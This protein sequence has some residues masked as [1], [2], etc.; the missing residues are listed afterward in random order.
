MSLSCRLPGLRRSSSRRDRFRDAVLT[1]LYG[2]VPVNVAADV[3]SRVSV[4]RSGLTYNRS[5]QQYAGTITFTNSSTT[6]IA[7][8]LRLLLFGLTL[9]VT[10]TDTTLTIGTA[11]YSLAIGTTAAGD[12]FL[13][14]PQ[15][16]L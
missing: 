14:V 7:G 1:V 2:T 11:T 4:A 15:A 9:G 12:P 5:T 13:I 6:S 3:S 16:L 10:L 8:S